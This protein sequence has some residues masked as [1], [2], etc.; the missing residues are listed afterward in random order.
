MSNVLQSFEIAIK[1]GCIAR[2]VQVCAGQIP[3]LERR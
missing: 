2:L 1:L 3:D